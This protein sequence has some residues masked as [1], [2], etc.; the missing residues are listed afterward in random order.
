MPV[1]RPPLQGGHARTSPRVSRSAIASP[2]SMASAR[3]AV[4]FFPVHDLANEAYIIPGVILP[5]TNKA[6]KQGGD[7]PTDIT[8][9]S[10]L[11]HAKAK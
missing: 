9:K 7:Y 1:D 4:E 2:P 6:M 5:S 3:V 10:F 11:D 8:E